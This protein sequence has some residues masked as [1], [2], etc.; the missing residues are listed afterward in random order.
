MDYKDYYQ[1]LGVAKEATPAEIKKAYRKLAVKY[2]PDKNQGN[3]EAEAKFKEVAE[4][5][6][7]LKDPEKRKKYDELGAN[8]KHYQHQGASAG[9]P[10][11]SYSQG[12]YQF[13]GDLNDLFGGGGGNFS[14]FFQSF[15]GGGFGG[16][17]RSGSGGAGFKG[18]DYQAEA[19]IS[20][21][22]AYQ[23]TTRMLELNGKKLRIKIKPGVSDGQMLKIKGRGAP[24]M[25]G[26]AAGDLYIKVSISPHPSY[27]RKGVDLYKTV[28]VDLYTA[29]LGGKI[30][31][32]TF[33][34]TVKIAVPQGAESGKLLRLKDRGMPYYDKSE[35]FGNMYIR[36]NVK[37]PQN[38]SAEEVELF[39]QLQKM[40]G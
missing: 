6:E 14:D 8:W 10:Y 2:H 39:K 20:L 11:G 33:R 25:Q 16:Q 4:A 36:I 9:S 34:G 27:E 35:N 21:E 15:F 30:P 12:G 37:L 7:V 40:R 24:G 5:H 22:E 18:Q 28:D 31:V 26:G 23:G 29:V 38:L 17:T 3:K 1:V 19:T 13:E 32:E